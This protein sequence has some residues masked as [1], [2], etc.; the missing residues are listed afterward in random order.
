VKY[1]S[2]I[3]QVAN[4]QTNLV[5]W[6][7]EAG[8]TRLLTVADTNT[9]I[10]AKSENL[11]TLSPTPGNPDLVPDETALGRIFVAAADA[12]AI[13]AVGSGTIC[14][15]VR[16]VSFR[17]GLPYY[18]VATAASMDGYTSSV[19]PL[20]VDGFKQTFVTAAPVGVIVDPAIYTT[21]PARLTAAGF[22]DMMGKFTSVVDWEME[23]LLFPENDDFCLA[24]ANEMRK[25]AEDCYISGDVMSALI[26]SGLIMQKVGN[27][28]PA[29][30]S[31]H[32]LSH[33]WEM[34]ALSEGKLPALHGAKVGVAT[35]AVLQATEW[36]LDEEIN[37]ARA[38]DFDVHE[39]KNEMQNSF[40]PT[41]NDILP[42]WADENPATRGAL[43]ERIKN[44]WAE[45]RKILSQNIGLRSKLEKSIASM[46]GPTTPAKIGV[47][48]QEFFTG[49]LYANRLRRRFTVW[50]LLDLLGL[51]PQYAQKLTDQVN[52]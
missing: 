45:L 14:D 5:G 46:D 48:R 52:K 26:I 43:L 23:G 50:R 24:S 22:S 12:Q 20:T 2:I 6:L 9:A 10:F 49:I 4:S 31:E 42:L 29:S 39:W 1:N 25:T 51:L 44:H 18:V 21:A 19:A 35:L 41:A 34:K 15:L 3:T 47:D 40:G 30:G 33:F 11:L 17:L 7:Q 32:H 37:W 27:S 13:V 8:Y 36:L 28:K 16:Y 38:D